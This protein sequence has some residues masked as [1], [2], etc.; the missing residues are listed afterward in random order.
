MK[1]RD[2]VVDGRKLDWRQVHDQLLQ[3]AGKAAR[4]DWGIG[5]VLLLA[6]KARCHTMLGM[7]SLHEYAERVLGYAPHTTEERLRVA[8]ALESLPKTNAAAEAGELPWSAVRELTRVATADTEAKWLAAAAN[9]RVRDV[10]RLVRGR[11]PGDLPD[12]PGDPELETHVL[13]FEVCAETYAI[14]REM[15]AHLQRLAGEHLEPDALLQLAARHVLGGPEAGRA[16]YQIALTTCETCQR[17]WQR[18]KGELVAVEE[19]V[20]EKAACD[21][22]HIGRVDASGGPTR[23]TQTIPPATRRFVLEREGGCCAVPGCSNATF[24]DLHHTQ[25]RSEGGDHDPKKLLALCSAHHTAAHDGRL[26]IDG[27]AVRGWCFRHADGSVYGSQPDVLASD[28][29]AAA[30]GALT[31]YGFQTQPVQQALE[32][33]RSHVGAAAT[34]GDVIRAAR[35]R[36]TPPG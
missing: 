17:T 36:L 25:L 11:K 2:T 35:L 5:R 7:G 23:A 3:L 34:A 21:G 4:I 30:F 12:S 22:Q 24:L 33:V 31:H 10:E 15:E 32:E 16:S 28:A 9:L 14:F 13:R 18:G 20:R 8:R 19:A 29:F 1:G 27:D 26:L 6:A